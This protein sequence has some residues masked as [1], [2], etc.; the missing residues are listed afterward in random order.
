VNRLLPRRLRQASVWAPVAAGVG[1]PA[2]A[3]ADPAADA[4]YDRRF[5]TECEPCHGDRGRGDR[6]PAP[7]LAG[8]PSFY[9]ITQLFLFRGERRDSPEMT[10]VAKGFSDD[11]LRGFSDA[12][13]RLP[14]ITLPIPAPTVDAASWQRGKQMARQFHCLVCHGAAFEGG[15]QTPRLAGQREDYLLRALTGFR[16]GRRVGYTNAMGEALAGLDAS[17]IAD[18][19]NY[20]ANWM[21]DDGSAA[22]DGGRPSAIGTG[23]TGASR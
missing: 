14:A 3:K 21:P 22:V 8:Q 6:S 1:W 20:L 11:D 15:R 4:A 19:A 5:V 7:M 16:A 18:L 17:Q 10:A 2:A 13:G 12:I 23:T 9:A